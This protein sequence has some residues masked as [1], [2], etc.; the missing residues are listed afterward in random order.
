[1]APSRAEFSTLKIYGN[2]TYDDETI[3]SILGIDY[4]IPLSDSEMK[5]KLETTGYFS[6]IRITH[7]GPYTIL[8]V[9]EKTPWFILPYFS[10]D[11]DSK[12]YGLAGGLMGIN[13]TEGMIVG[14]AQTST[15]NKAFGLLYRDDYFLDSFWILGA[16][17]DYENAKHSVYNGREIQ[18]RT[19][20]HATNFSQQ[21]GYHLRPDLLVR[22]DSHIESHRFEEVDKVFFDGMQWS[23][24]M[25]TEYG[26]YYLNEGLARGYLIKPYFEF[27]NPLS[28]FKFFQLGISSQY[29]VYLKNNFNWITRPRFEYGNS[30]PRYQQFELG[31]ANLRGFP[32]QSFRSQSYSAIQNDFLLTVWDIKSIKV[33]PILYADWAYI[34]NGGRTALGTGLQVYFKHIAVPAIQIYGGYGFHPNGFSF[35]A[36]IGPQL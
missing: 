10:S 32:A 35:T 24:R 36:A 13:G 18:Q 33:R 8:V 20:N 1:M 19:E 15:N 4:D 7:S 3:K 34:Q 26:S 28:D 22:F 11:A 29:S 30:L 12:I 2:H 6:R 9:R 23:H 16:S 17:L 25:F 27:T 31:G 5:Q 14:R 21:L